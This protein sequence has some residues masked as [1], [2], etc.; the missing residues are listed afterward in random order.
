LTATATTSRGSL[1]PVVGGI[2][3]ALIGFTGAFS[4]VLA[5]LRG[6]GADER[7]AASGLLVVCVASGVAAIWLSARHREPIAV[8]WS[9]PG[10]ALLATAGVP[11]GGWS[12]AV[13]G[14]AVAGVLVVLAGTWRRLGA[15]IAAVPAGL[16]SAMLAGVLLPLCLSPARAVVDVPLLA[17]PVVLVWAVLARFARRW[18][19]PVAILTAAVAVVVDRGLPASGAL[20]L[21]ELAFTTPTLTAASIVGIA[22]PLFLVTMASQNLPGMAVMASYGYRP[23]MRPIL[24]TTGGGSLLG[25]P[26]GGHAICL[27]AITAALTSGPDAGPDP[28]RRWIASATAGATLAVLGLCAGLVTAFVAAAPAVLV[29]AV[30]GLALLGALTGA[31]SA[32]MAEPDQREAAVVTLLVSASGIMALGVSAPFWG[33]L[34]GLALLGLQRARRRPVA[35]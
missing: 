32:A 2:V 26:F 5:G 30:A 16:A 13:G 34:A 29:Q 4:V 10:A 7:Q 33:L 15:L 6:A 11:A 12:A 1:Q 23:D 9:T 27:A 3:T 35:G 8:A 21:P 17:A 19:V 31:L 18:A 22:V 20:G 25:A 28:G 14:F 24:I